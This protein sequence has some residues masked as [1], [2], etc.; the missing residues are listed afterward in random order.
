MRRPWP[1][2]L[3]RL[4]L[5]ALL[6]AG[7]FT[8]CSDSGDG[9]D[10][11]YPSLLTELVEAH[12][13]ADS[14][15]ASILTDQGVSYTLSQRIPAFAS[16]TVLRC[17]ATYLPD[18]DA[19]SS[20]SSNTASAPTATLYQLQHVYSE[21]PRPR[22]QFA[23]SVALPRDPVRIL[24][25]WQTDRWLNLYLGVPTHTNIT[26]AFAFCADSLTT[27]ADSARAT[28]HV[29]LLHRQPEADTPD[30]TQKTYLSLPLA[31]CAAQADSL[32]LGIVTAD[33]G[34]HILS[35]RLR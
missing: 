12:V 27:D 17:L 15:V 1:D 35:F 18:D 32:R 4:A 2:T 21:A 34:E 22:A 30:F 14:V 7:A 25:A 28:L 23:D 20:A 19:S 29:S 9:Q 5:P 33:G 10:G 13:G 24:S 3:V 31:P 8:A 26:H 6:A 16:D 11:I